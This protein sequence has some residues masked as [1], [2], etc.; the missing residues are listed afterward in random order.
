MVTMIIRIPHLGHI[1]MAEV[2]AQVVCRH[3]AIGF[4][5]LLYHLT[6]K[7]AFKIG[8]IAF[9]FIIH[10]QRILTAPTLT[11]QNDGGLQ[12][13]PTFFFHFPYSLVFSSTRTPFSSA[14][15]SFPTASEGFGNH[16]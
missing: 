14:L 10:I 15:F 8:A 4:A 3:L 9:V 6:I 16:N 11:V 2:D 7:Y 13:L 1:G 12:C 5:L